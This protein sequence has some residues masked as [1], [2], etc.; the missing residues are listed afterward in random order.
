MRKVYLLY[1]TIYTDTFHQ[2]FSVW[3]RTVRGTHY[4]LETKGSTKSPGRQFYACLLQESPHGTLWSRYK[5][6][7]IV[8]D[9]LLSDFR[10]NVLWHLSGSS[11]HSQAY[12]C[13][14]ANCHLLGDY[15]VHLPCLLPKVQPVQRKQEYYI[16]I[17]AELK[18]ISCT[19][20][21]LCRTSGHSK[22]KVQAQG[23]HQ[24]FPP[25]PPQPNSS[26][27]CK[28]SIENCDFNHK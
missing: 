28:A 7:R 16:S 13:R 25:H 9:R 19:S 20:F 27:L 21:S 12:W 18:Y 8:L 3:R 23:L 15:P 10:E 26:Q 22:S 6:P 1:S 11:A 17:T 2:Q 5:S 4:L 24:G 14:Q